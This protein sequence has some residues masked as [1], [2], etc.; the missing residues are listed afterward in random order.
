[1]KRWQK[2]LGLAQTGTLDPGQVVYE[3][4]AVRVTK[5]LAEVGAQ[6]GG[7]VLQV[8]STSRVVHVDLDAAK[9]ADVHVGDAVQVELPDERRTGAEV[10]SIGT[11]STSQDGSSTLPV[12]L[13][14]D[15]PS[16]GGDLDEVPV[17]VLVTTSS[18]A[19]VL[20]APVQA[21]LALAEGGY[22]VEKVTGSSTT[23]LVAVELGPSAG[24]WV[25]VTGAV[26]EGDVVVVAP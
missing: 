26:H 11:V 4:G 12:E 15:D 8:T 1:V 5:H 22:A 25:Q 2:A 19:G 24:G 20:A 14:L 9:Q 23:K 6:A 16:A 17:S 21:L 18:A 10:A 3:P 13:T 7:P